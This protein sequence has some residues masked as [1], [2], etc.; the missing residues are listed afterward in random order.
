MTKVM[1]ANVE[2]KV[3]WNTQSWIK[4]TICVE[5]PVT[6][7]DA[8]WFVRVRKHSRFGTDTWA[9]FEPF[10]TEEKARIFAN[11]AW[12]SLRDGTWHL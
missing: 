3:Q 4:Y 9:F 10:T 12:T 1:I 7:H 6:E 2:P 5:P 11:T 8:R